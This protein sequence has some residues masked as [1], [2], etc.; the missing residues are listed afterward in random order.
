MS[1]ASGAVLVASTPK[2][3]AAAGRPSSNPDMQL[4]AKDVSVKVLRL[5]TPIMSMAH[6]PGEK[7]GEVIGMGADAYIHRIVLPADGQAWAGL[8]GRM[9]KSAAR[10]SLHARAGGAVAVSANHQLVVTGS[11]D[12]TIATH[13]ASLMTICTMQGTANNSDIV[14]RSASSF[15]GLTGAAM[16]PPTIPGVHDVTEQGVCA[17][18][19]DYRWARASIGNSSQLMITSIQAALLLM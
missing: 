6:I 9:H 16:S 3:L 8:K 1:L 15:M 11:E 5:E 14:S 17:V 12:G 10:I 2:E 7:Y 13:T 19:F 4:T 18:T